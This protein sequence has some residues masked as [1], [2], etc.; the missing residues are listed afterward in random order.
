MRR[1][2]DDVLFH[3]TQKPLAVM[4]WCLRLR[5]T[6][7]A[8]TILDPYMGSGTSLVAA[9]DLG[10]KAIGIEICEAYCEVAAR[11]LQQEV[12]PI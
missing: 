5:W 3:P 11:R 10:R 4:Q 9:K 8:Q 6:Q 12:L 1:K 7:D 2:G